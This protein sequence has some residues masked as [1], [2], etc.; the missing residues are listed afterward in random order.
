MASSTK[1]KRKKPAFKQLNHG[2][3]KRVKSSWRKPRGTHNKK[4]MKQKWT[5]ASPRV[6][7]GNDARVRGLHPRGKGEALVTHLAQLEALK[8]ADVVVRLS[9]TLGARKRKLISEKAA[10]MKLPLLN[11]GAKEAWKKGA[12]GGSASAPKKVK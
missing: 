7:Y 8:G 5:G 6:G 10:A 2:H 4:R 11:S 1:S 3:K 12:K 9:S